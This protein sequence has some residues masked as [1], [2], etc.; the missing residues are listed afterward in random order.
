VGSNF[1]R[2]DDAERQ[3]E[4]CFEV[5]AHGAARL[6]ASC[7]RHA[8]PLMTFSSGLVF[9]GLRSRPYL[10][11]D[12][13]APLNVYGRSKLRAENRVLE[14][15]PD[16]LVIRTSAFFSPWDESNFVTTALRALLA[17]ENII[18]AGD[19]II[20]PTYVADL[21]HAALDLLIDGENGIWHL[22]NK[23]TM[24]WADLARR[25]AEIAGVTSGVVEARPAYTMGYTATRPHY[26]ALGSERGQLLPTVDDALER[27]LCECE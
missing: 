18:A 19:L 15:L 5:N 13:P 10:E 20:S 4:E 25:A 1:V 17:G 27:Y 22:S 2:V 12:V 8:I 3:Q 26:S 16:S 14:I 7:A 24:S 11:S 21:V 6:A 9:D 23:G